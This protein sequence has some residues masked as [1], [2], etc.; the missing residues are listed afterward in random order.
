VKLIDLNV[1][2][3]VINRDVPQHAQVHAWWKQALADEDLLGLSWSVI[4]GFLRLSTNSKVF[5]SP[6]SIDAAIQ[7]VDEW[8][9][10]PR[11][12]IVHELPEH[13]TIFRSLLNATGAAGNLTSDVHLAA[14]SLSHHATLVTCDRDF[15]R[16]A[17]LSTLDPSSGAEPES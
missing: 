3:Y 4:L 11:I 8:L 2:L 13:W 15:K 5:T 17:Q 16:F 9:T 7:C 1:L 14:L 12:Q 6:L 10:H